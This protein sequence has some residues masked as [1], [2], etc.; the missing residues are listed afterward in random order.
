LLSLSLVLL[1]SISAAENQIGATFNSEGPGPATGPRGTVGSADNPPN[2]T[3]TGAVEAIATDPSNPNTI[4]VGAVGGGIWK[5][6]NG[7]ANWI[8]LI[9]QNLS[10]SIGSLSLDPTDPTHQT[11]IAGNGNL[12]NGG[13]A[14]TSVFS[15]PQN[16]GGVLAGL[17]YSTDGGAT[18]VR[19]GATTF[20]GQSVVDVASRG[21]TILAATAEPRTMEAGASFFSGGLYRST[22]GGNTFSLIGP[23]NGLPS[24][25]VTS[26]VGDPANPNTY[27]AAVTANSSATY[28]QT[29]VYR[30]RWWR[31]VVRR[32]H[33]GTKRRHHQRRRANDN[34]AR[35]RIGWNSRDRR[36]QS[37][38]W[39]AVGAFLF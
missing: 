5:T 26:L 8:P 13:F 27:Y 17:L 12:S 31:D 34:Q 36:G 30:Y 7:G 38:H 39:H 37:W 9:D 11:V 28:A 23:G 15:T 24:G 25:P 4:Y 16:F 19:L 22:N 35:G 10:L 21:S 2:G 14:S 3:V 20:S 32:V 29:S 6:T 33:L 1:P 18:F